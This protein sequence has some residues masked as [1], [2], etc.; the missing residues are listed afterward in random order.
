VETFCRNVIGGFASSRFHRPPSG[1]GLSRTSINCLL[2][3]RKIE[4]KVKFRDL[5]PMMNL[6]ETTGK[7]KHSFLQKE[8]K[9]Y[10]LYFTGPGTQ[11]LTLANGIRLLS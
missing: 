11:F 4:E 2:T 3:I 9:N 7:I 5:T 8:E 6:L 1:L 10:V